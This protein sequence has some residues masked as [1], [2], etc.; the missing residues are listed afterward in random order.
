MTANLHDVSLSAFVNP[1]IERGSTRVF[2]SLSCLRAALEQGQD[3][4]LYGRLGGQTHRRLEEAISELEGAEGT[5]LT[6]SGLSAVTCAL[7]ACVSRGDHVLLADCIYEPSRAFCDQ[8][9]SRFGVE[10]GYFEARHDAKIE[11]HIRPNTRALLCESP[12]SVTFE[13]LDLRALSALTR[14]RGVTLIVDGTWATPL[15]CNPLALGVDIVVHSGTKYILGHADAFLG[16][17]SANGEALKRVRSSA[18]CLGLHVGPEECYLA[19]RGLRTLSVRMEQHYRSGLDIARWLQNRR[20]VETVLHP[21]LP[22]DAGHAVWR[23]DYRGASSVFSF[24]LKP[25]PSVA[26][27]AFFDGLSLFGIGYGWGGFESL[28]MPYDVASLRTATRWHREGPLVRIHVGLEAVVALKAELDAALS[29][30]GTFLREPEAIDAVPWQ[31]ETIVP[32]P[33]I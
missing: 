18:K 25:A 32:L 11:E 8:M 5:V 24:V 13:M 3:G 10:V 7:L 30:Y 12:G 20:E 26:L 22:D 21:A 15:F 23:R 19:L 27:D 31:M 17:L 14:A 1:P 16:T 6:P 2:R 29:R 9:L 4:T 28:V 33:A